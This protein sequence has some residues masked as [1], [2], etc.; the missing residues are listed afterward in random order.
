MDKIN[1]PRKKNNLNKTIVT[2]IGIA[3]LGAGAGAAA[4]AS[5]ATTTLATVPTAQSALGNGFGRGHRGPP[6]VIGTVTSVSGQ[7]VTITDKSGTV[8]TADLSNAKIT[9]NVVGAS[10]PTTITAADIAA[11]DTIGVRG[12]I[13]GNTVTATFAMDGISLTAQEGGMKGGRGDHGV[14]GKVTAVSGTTVTVLGNDGKTYTIDA[15][16]A[17]VSKIAT[18]T[19]A[20]II[21]GDEIG[22]QGKVTD[23]TVVAN[24]IMDWMPAHVMHDNAA[25]ATTAP[26]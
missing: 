3:A 15:G 23:T 9:K 12:T 24:E 26:Q 17:K 5:A 20:D 11:G 4:I 2:F 16:A 1:D 25:R 22:V 6:G 14:R 13:S 7:S 10:A 18:I 21:V 19:T 8:Y